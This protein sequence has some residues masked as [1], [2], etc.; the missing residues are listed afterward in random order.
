MAHAASPSL[1]SLGLTNDASLERST[2]RGGLAVSCVLHALVLVMALFL[3]FHSDSEQPFRAID[4]ALISLPA[5]PTTAPSP[6]PVP[7]PTKKPA[8]AQAPK[9]V[10]PP[11]PSPTAPPVPAEDT[12]PPLPTETASERLS[13]FLSGA[14]NSIV[15]PEKQEATESTLPPQEPNIHPMEDQSPLIDNLQLPSAPPTIARP[16]QLQRAEPLNIPSSKVPPTTTEPKKTQ[17]LSKPQPLESPTTEGRVQPAVKPAPAVPSLSEV[18]PFQNSQ[19]TTT[20][21]NTLPSSNMEESLQKSLPN[22]IPTHTPAPNVPEISRKRSTTQQESKSSTQP[23]MSETIKKLMEGLKSTTRTPTPKEV[24]PQLT[25]PLTKLPPSE[26]DQRIAK[27]SIPDVAPVE[28][29]KQRLQLLEVQATGNLEPSASKPSQGKNRY[30]AMVEDAI[31]GQWVAPPL[32][33]ST[34]LVIM[35]FRISRSGEISRMHIAESSGHAYYDSAA[36]RAVQA[37]N[38]LPPFPSDI[39]ESFFDVQYRFIKD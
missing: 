36:Q 6:K 26:L 2:F 35:K 11:K 33:A 17:A 4:V 29:I 22:N 31:D 5:I 23:K 18:T 7:A 9:K 12:L 28:S 25:K 14:I 13:E 1:I 20:P 38:P 34:P 15:V 21:P 37:V 32:L 3:R 30:L 39:S 24:P 8:K 10:A 27:L 19:Q 16:K